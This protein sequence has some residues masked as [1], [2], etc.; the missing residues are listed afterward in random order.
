MRL[1]NL[2][3]LIVLAWV[4]GG[5]ADEGMWPLSEIRQLNLKKQ[6]L[7]MDP[8]KI[9]NPDGVSLIDAIVKVGGCTGSFVSPEGLI[10]T[11]HHCAYRAAQA[12][13]T[14]EHD[15]IRD[16]FLARSREEEIPAK[17]Y[18]VRI[19]ESYRDVSRE[20]LSAVTPEMDYAARTRAIRRKIKEI[21]AEAERKNPGKRAEVSEMFV[22]KT[23]VLFLYTYLKDVRLVYVPPR[24]I[25]EF[26]GE[27]D[28]WIWPRHTG[29]FSFLR[30]YVA[31]DGSPAEYASENV[32]YRP[33]QF[34]S[35]NPEGVDKGDFLFILGYPGRTYR[36]RTSYFLAFE[37]DVR[38]PFVASLYDW[39]IQVMEQA[40]RQ[41]R[42]VMLK[43]LSRIKSRANVMKNYRGKL[44]GLKRLRLVE[45]RRAEEKALQAFIQA[46]SVRREKYGQLLTRIEQVYRE[47][48]KT[49]RRDL[50]LDYLPR[51]SNLFYFALTIYKASIE[52]A[53]PDLERE[54]AFMDRNY[55]RTKE[56]ILLA[57]KDYYEPT[58]RILLKDMLLRAAR[59]PGD[60]RIKVLDDLIGAEDP[61]T[62]IDRLLDAMY[63]KTMLDQE[64]IVYA[65][66]EQPQESLKVLD[67]PFINL[68]RNLYPAYRKLKE[69]RER[70][71]GELDPL[72]AKL[73]EVKKQFLRK[74]FVPDANGTLRLTYG[75]VRGYSPRDAVYYQPISTLRGVVEKT[76]GEEPF[77][78][79]AA[80]LR[81]IERRDFGRFVLKR[82]GSVPVGILYDTDTTGGNSG[83]PILDARGRLIGVN[84]DRAFEATIND[85]AWS[86]DYS[87]SI[88][89]DI[90]YVL[91]VTQK[92]G[93]ATWLL[94]E[95][96]VPLD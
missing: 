54:A 64:R 26:G 59:L 66:L 40:G 3:F 38:L 6:G 24:S 51:S 65:A 94:E 91:W 30:V 43:H 7:K 29:D 85:Y 75:H 71:K 45:K 5:L 90:R 72:L 73:V 88:G 36:H 53:K 2:V 33:R 92:F 16:G 31:P 57:L 80:L 50:I 14:P 68:A 86:E 9:Y 18:T 34:L 79:P 27:E 17:G 93:G 95:M 58:D 62:A 1:R 21:V 25:G 77:D 56:R 60:Q 78:T 63:A 61:E 19:T 42:E 41:N 44:L 4:I 37:E 84:F 15:Y 47:M 13:S 22:G 69:E 48:R 55:P 32:P 8:G 82:L 20:V 12:A 52:R 89:V 11:N 10:L 23:Y 74:K 96:G 46:D 81:L 87:R 67:D 28:N 76:T 35:V 49:A 83:S 39:Q 70:R